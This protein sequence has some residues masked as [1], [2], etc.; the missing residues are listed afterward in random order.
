MYPG[1]GH[2]TAVIPPWEGVLDSSLAVCF[3]DRRSGWGLGHLL[4][5][6]HSRRWWEAFVSSTLVRDGRSFSWSLYTVR[7]GIF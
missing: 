3:W 6:F 2:S 1:G 4:R 7:P 5:S